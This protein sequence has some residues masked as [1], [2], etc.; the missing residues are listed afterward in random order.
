MEK[1][2][3]I[4]IRSSSR[5]QIDEAL[6]AFQQL[7]EPS[8]VNPFNRDPFNAEELKDI[9]LYQNCMSEYDL[10]LILHWN[11]KHKSLL[12]SGLGYLLADSFSQF[13]QINHSIWNH[14]LI[15]CFSSN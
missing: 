1:I 2:E 10:A 5:D 12:K 9:K 15:Q 3:I 8:H 13:G 6:R 14:K 4:Q 7:S 11:S